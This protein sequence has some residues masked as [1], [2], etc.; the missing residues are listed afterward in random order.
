MKNSRKITIGTV[1]FYMIPV[2][3]LCAAVFFGYLYYKDF[4]EY[5]EAEDE[6]ADIN[7]N[8]IEIIPDGGSDA[9]SET[10]PAGEDEAEKM[11]E[12]FPTLDID[13]QSL[14]SLNSRMACVLYIPAVDITYPVAYSEDNEDYLHK[15]FEGKY[16][17]AG[18]I[19]YDYLS[20]RGFTGLNTF[21]FGHNMK[22]GSMFGKLKRFDSDSSLCATDPYFY[23][24]T[25]NQIRKYKIFSYYHTVNNSDTYM[26]VPD[27]ET[28]DTYIKYCQ[29]NSHFKDYDDIDFTERPGLV[30]LSTC[31]GRSGG[32]ER[33]VVHGA[34]V[35]M[36]NPTHKTVLKK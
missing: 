6:Y 8:Y 33:F 17:F 35:A 7:D 21:I 11:P 26:D 2:I 10:L 16:N 30:T 36:K 32:N 31:A 9:D 27:E 5:K 28:Y 34:L 14:K 22:N 18:C 20:E 12:Y 1:I 19:F 24:Y 4:R 13:F 3:A 23:I 29:R 25:D 15:T